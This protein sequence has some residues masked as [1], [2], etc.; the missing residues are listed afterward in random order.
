MDWTVSPEIFRIGAF[1]IRWYSLMFILSFTLGYAIIKRILQ[2]E[3]KAE[4]D[5]EDLFLYMFIAT[6][7]GARLGHCLFYDPGY[8]LANPLEIIM[9]H[10]GGLASH[11][12]AVG[13]LT[14]LYLYAKKRPDQSFLWTVDRI[15]IVVALSGF[16]IRMGNLF[17]SEIVGKPTDVPWAFR[18]PFYEANPVPRH[19]TQLYEAIAYLVVFAILF[20]YYRSRQDRVNQGFLLGLFLVLVFGFRF[21]VEFLKENQEAWEAA[22][23]LNMGQLLSIPFVLIGVWLILQAPKRGPLLKADTPPKPGKVDPRKA[24][25]KRRKA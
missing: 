13:I 2:W 25:R 22:L 11:G 4:S 6:I 19:P 1:P 24:G 9:I 14:A 3:H 23:T 8:Y 5:L 21:L 12:A 20:W 15:V 17:N 16:F 10:H 7:A 18:F